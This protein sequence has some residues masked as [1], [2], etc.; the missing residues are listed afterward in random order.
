MRLRRL[1]RFNQVKWVLV[2]SHFNQQLQKGWRGYVALLS[3]V[4][5]CANVV[6]TAVLKAAYRSGIAL[7]SAL[8]A[9]AALCLFRVTRLRGA[10][11]ALAL[12]GAIASVLSG[13]SAPDDDVEASDLDAEDAQ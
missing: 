1:A 4:S 9:A 8:V 6:A 10:L 7:P 2:R 3:F 5:L 13:R 11:A 12:G